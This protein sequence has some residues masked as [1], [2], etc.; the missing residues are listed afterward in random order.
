MFEGLFGVVET[1]TLED[2]EDRMMSHVVS[3]QIHLRF[4]QYQKSH[5]KSL[6]V[7]PVGHLVF[8]D[9]VLLVV[10]HHSKDSK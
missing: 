7:G 1:E 5:R 8:D 2:G 4:F 6:S 10:R 9:L 3:Y